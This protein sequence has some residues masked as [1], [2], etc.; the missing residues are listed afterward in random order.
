LQHGSATQPP[1]PCT[2]WLYLYHTWLQRRRAQASKTRHPHETEPGA[3]Q[4]AGHVAE[5]ASAPEAGTRG[6]GT[7]HQE[8]RV[9]FRDVLVAGEN[10]CGHVAEP[11]I[12]LHNSTR[13][14]NV[15]AGHQKQGGRS[16]PVRRR[17][18]EQIDAGLKNFV[19]V[20]PPSRALPVWFSGWD[21]FHPRRAGRG[22]RPGTTRNER[23]TTHVGFNRRLLFL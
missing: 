19:S 8:D 22:Y 14:R 16:I 7:G 12:R 23:D 21:I 10:T 20:P 13:G 2:T 6:G 15:S 11:E 1:R 3:D 9:D 5:S 18:P 17:S 4:P